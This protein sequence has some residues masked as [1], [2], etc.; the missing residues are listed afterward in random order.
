MSKITYDYIRDYLQAIEK[1]DDEVIE[2]IKKYAIKNNVPIIK[3]EMKQLLEVLLCVHKPKTIL[4]IG[5][6]IG[7]SSI[8]MSKYIGDDGKIT[9]I[10]RNEQM[11][12]IACSNIKRIGKDNNITIINKDAKNALEE[13]DGKYDMIFMDAAKGQYLTFLPHCLRLLK[14]GG[15]LVSDNVLQDGF[16]AKSRFSVPRRQR[17]IHQRM[18][19]YLWQLNHMEELKT[20]ILPISDGATISYKL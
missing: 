7:Y 17:T 6:A 19:E 2:D 3:T 16:V 11:Y 4:E 15:I 13:L 14:T 12:K 8:I 18:R 5:T 9:T 10:E 20:S 1:T